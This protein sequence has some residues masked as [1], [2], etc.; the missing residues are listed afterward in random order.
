[1]LELNTSPPRTELRPTSQ[2]TCL[3][4]P[5]CVPVLGKL[6]Q[7]SP[8]AGNQPAPPQHP[9]AAVTAHS[10]THKGS[11]TASRTGTQRGIQSPGPV[12]QTSQQ[13]Q[14]TREKQHWQSLCS[15][16]RTAL[17][18]LLSPRRESHNRMKLCD[19]PNGQDGPA[20][21]HVQCHCKARPEAEPRAQAIFA[22]EAA[23]LSPEDRQPPVPQEK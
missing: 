13:H 12:F 4:Q 1:M 18:S 21:S 15:C 16:P 7:P 14:R 23:A 8:A 3:M 19:S 6:L 17:R 2:P 10:G 11:R 9:C 5:M 22:G 20:G